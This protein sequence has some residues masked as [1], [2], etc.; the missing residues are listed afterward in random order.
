MR[1]FIAGCF[2]AAFT[3]IA[4]ATAMV[5]QPMVIDLVPGTRQGA[6]L[7][8]VENTFSLPLTVEM[9]VHEA[10][11]GETGLAATTRESNDLLAFP[12]QALIP[13]GQT[14]TFRVQWVGDVV[15]TTSHHYFVTVAQLPVEFPEGQSAVQLLYNFDVAVNVAVPALEPSIS[16][17]AAEAWTNPETGT[18]R[19]RITFANSSSTYGYVSD[20]RVRVNYT[21]PDGRAAERVLTP[22]ELRDGI[23]FGLVAAQAS[24]T[25]VL[26]V[27][28]AIAGGAVEAVFIPPR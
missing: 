17:T 16:V 9:R 10:E 25:L 8:T 28:L 26:P 11:P 21:A 7:V 22:R 5:V 24:R 2:I 12:P 23:G 4:P 3:T 1:R 14:Q 6:A 13:P 18:V 20:G 19:P 15:P 27:D